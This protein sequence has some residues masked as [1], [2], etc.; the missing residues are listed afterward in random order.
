VT[1]PKHPLFGRRFTVLRIPT[2][3]QGSPYI[4]VAYREYMALRIPLLA[5]NLITSQP[6][7][8]TK[9]TYQAL[10]ELVALAQECEVLCTT[11]LAKSGPDCQ[12]SNSNEFAPNYP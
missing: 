12:P 4:W 2:T 9:L 7:S 11:N 6:M 5:T 1:D 8:Q 10:T 3:S